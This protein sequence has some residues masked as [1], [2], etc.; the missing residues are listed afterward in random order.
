MDITIPDFHQ[1]RVLG[2]KEY[3]PFPER[4]KGA[5]QRFTEASIRALRTIGYQK[6]FTIVQ[7]RMNIDKDWL[8]E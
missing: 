3:M 2:H 4:V 7:Q 1:A 5:Y 6:A 8:H